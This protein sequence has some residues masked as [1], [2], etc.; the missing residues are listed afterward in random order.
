[1]HSKYILEV[2]FTLVVSFHIYPSLVRKMVLHVFLQRKGK[3]KEEK[4]GVTG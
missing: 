1:V 2:I 3:K 4:R